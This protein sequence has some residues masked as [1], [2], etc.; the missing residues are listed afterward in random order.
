MVHQDRDADEV[1]VAALAA[2]DEDA[3]KRRNDAKPRSRRYRA[4]TTASFSE[5]V[6]LVE[7]ESGHLRWTLDLRSAARTRQTSATR[8]TG[9]FDGER[10]CS[11]GCARAEARKW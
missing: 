1:K 9:I 3:A 4:T 8:P 2:M 10:R 5:K 7:D 11:R 6:E